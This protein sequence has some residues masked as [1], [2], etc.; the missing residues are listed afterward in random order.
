MKSTKEKTQVCIMYDNMNIPLN[1]L[2]AKFWAK[3]FMN[4]IF[5]KSTYKGYKN[6]NE[7]RKH[8]H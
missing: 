5:L 4:C 2:Y 7:E 3:Y 6:V 1:L 8:C